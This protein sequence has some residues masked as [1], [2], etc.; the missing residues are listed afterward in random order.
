MDRLNENFDLSVTA[1]GRLGNVI[2]SLSN[3]LFIAEKTKSRLTLGMHKNKGGFLDKQVWDFCRDEEDLHETDFRGDKFFKDHLV[4]KKFNIGVPSFTEGC[5]ILRKHLWPRV[6]SF[7]HNPKDH[8]VVLHIRSGDLF[9][10]D[11][12]RDWD[13][14]QPP[15]SFYE[16]VIL[17]N[18][19][20]RPLIVAEPDR[21]NPAIEELI[22]RFP[23]ISIQS[24]SIKDDWL[25]L[26][27]STS[28]ICS[29]SSFALMAA[30]TS[31][32]VKRCFFPSYACGIPVR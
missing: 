5:S 24:S 20:Q 27:H 16:K 32:K 6:G 10:G 23:N 3:A 9:S 17:D 28:L 26:C 18:D 12:R 8:D 30:V 25:T 22:R 7:D 2:Y 15:A 11:K 4:H 31:P 14:L 19:F 1:K 29:N 21:K 13:H